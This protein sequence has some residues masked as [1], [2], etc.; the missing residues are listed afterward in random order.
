MVCVLGYILG[1]NGLCS[2]IYIKLSEQSACGHCWSYKISE[3][4]SGTVWILLYSGLY[5]CFFFIS[6]HLPKLHW[7]VDVREC[8]LKGESSQIRIDLN[9]LEPGHIPVKIM[10]GYIKI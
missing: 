7:N 1:Y 2:W 5:V 4:L 6:L 3:C 8:H 10:W 9:D